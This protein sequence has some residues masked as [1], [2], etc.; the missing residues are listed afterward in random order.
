[1]IL[2]LEVVV[3]V[4]E[5]DD[6]LVLEVVDEDEKVDDEVTVD[7]LVNVDKV[8]FVELLEV[9]AVVEVVAVE[10]L[11]DDVV[12]VLVVLVVHV[13]HNTGHVAEV[14]AAKSGSNAVAGSQSA[15]FKKLH[16]T[17]S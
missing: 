9:V 6:M 7:W 16:A 14:S 12:V 4:D 13:R 8:V 1:V 10:I 5:D 3:C 15:A 11:V 2:E 17:G